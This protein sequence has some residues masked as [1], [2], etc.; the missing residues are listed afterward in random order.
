MQSLIALLTVANL[1]APP[2]QITVQGKL[3][4]AGGVVVDGSYTLTLGLYETKT[5]QTPVWS[6]VMVGTKVQNGVFSTVMNGISSQMVAN[7]PALWFSVKVETEPEQERTQITSTPYALVAD[8]ALALQCTNCITPA[9]TTFM[10][11]CKS[12]ETLVYNGTNWTCGGAGSSYTAGSGLSL[13][14]NQFKITNNGVTSAH[15]KDA[16]ITFTDLAANGCSNGQIMKRQNGVWACGSDANTG[17]TYSAG[18]GLSLNGASFSADFASSGGNN[19]T[20]TKVARSN[21]TH[22]GTYLETSGGT[23]NGNLTVSGDLTVG[24]TFTAKSTDITLLGIKQINDDA[25]TTYTYTVGRYHMEISYSP[26]YKATKEIP[27][28]ILEGFCGDEDGCTVIVSMKNFSTSETAGYV[29]SQVSR[30]F[31][32]PSSGQWRMSGGASSPNKDGKD[33][34]GTHQGH[35]MNA[36]DACFFT[37]SA[38]IGGAN[39]GDVK[40]GMHLL[41]WSVSQNSGQKICQLTL[42]D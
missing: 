37:E 25:P 18:A 26:Y 41:Y 5:S 36:F 4:N 29:A 16:D 17:T 23:V 7:A 1:G 9:M 30:L 12:G 15:I 14:N 21:H 27:Q 38:Y 20:N 13:T 32:H 40:K 24:G 19:G 39:Q 34:D 3:S 6:D 10:S 11:G 22:N 31:Y 8:R 2:P 35:A 28:N 33:G 42:M